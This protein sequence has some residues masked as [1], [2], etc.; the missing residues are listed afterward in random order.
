MRRIPVPEGR[1][2]RARVVGR[3]VVDEQQ[4]VGESE[5]VA[6]L[7]ETSHAV[8]KVFSFVEAGDDEAEIGRVL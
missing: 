3:T 4:L 5:P 8:A 6:R 1:E 2:D 7:H